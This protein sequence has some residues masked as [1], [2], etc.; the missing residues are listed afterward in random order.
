MNSFMEGG[1]R[2]P[3]ALFL[4][5]S[6]FLAWA[7]PVAVRADCTTET[8][9][10]DT[11]GSRLFVGAFNGRSIA[12]VFYAPDTLVQSVTVWRPASDQVNITGMHLYITG[13]HSAGAPDPSD[14]LLDGQT[15]VLPSTGA[16]PKPVVYSLDP[17]LA[18]PH[19]GLFAFAIK[20]DTPQ[21]LGI[22]NLMADSI[23]VYRDGDSWTIYPFYSCLGLGFG[24]APEPRDVVFE[25]A[26][27]EMGTPTLRTTWG[28][29]K[30]T[31]R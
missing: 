14:V 30:S 9:G 13:V 11:T 28:R 6:L 16:T 4:A 7:A 3:A 31:Y 10:I 20:Q 17:P 5:G 29:L 25:V 23:G 1:R 22:F 26:F 27:C 21:C 8:V 18:L 15:I 19:R 12:Q 24:P 2:V